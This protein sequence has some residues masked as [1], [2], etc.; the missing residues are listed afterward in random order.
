MHRRDRP[1]R[2]A[3]DGACEPGGAASARGGAELV[4]AAR[5][6]IGQCLL[7]FSGALVNAPAVVDLSVLRVKPCWSSATIARSMY[8]KLQRDANVS[9]GESGCSKRA[10]TA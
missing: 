2:H 6:A 10:I 3:A 9:S 8:Q 4:A 1:Q 5:G 7:G